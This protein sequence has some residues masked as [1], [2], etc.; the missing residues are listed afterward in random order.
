M[1]LKFSLGNRFYYYDFYNKHG[2]MYKL[3]KL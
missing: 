3:K 2:F 1:K